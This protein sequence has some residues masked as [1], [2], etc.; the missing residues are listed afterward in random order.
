MLRLVNVEF[1]ISMCLL[2]Q[3]GHIA[4]SHGFM[5][6]VWFDLW[7]VYVAPVGVA[8]RRKR[9]AVPFVTEGVIED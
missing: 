7:G 6:R 8:I 3:N 2:D 1:C 5:A 9:I 4:V